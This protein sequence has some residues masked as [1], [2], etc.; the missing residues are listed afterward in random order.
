MKLARAVIVLLVASG[1]FYLIVGRGPAETRGG[2]VAAKTKTVATKTAAKTAKTGP[3]K[4]PP[5]NFL[6]RLIRGLIPN[7]NQPLI[8]KRRNKPIT[9]PTGKDDA[10]SRSRLLRARDHIDSRAPH[11][12]DDLKRLRR[13]QSLIAGGE[14]ETAMK[15]I[16]RLLDREDDSLIRN[17]KEE[18]V[19]VRE[20]ANRLLGRSPPQIRA[21]YQLKYG[22]VARDR[23]DKALKSADLRSVADV[24]THYFHTKAGA[25]AAGKLC[26]VYLD[27][28]EYGTA[29]RWHARL[30][31][32]GLSAKDDPRWL[33]QAAYAFRR[34]GDEAESNRLLKRVQDLQRGGTVIVAGRPVQPAEWLKRF[35]PAVNGPPTVSEWWNLY[36]NPSR[37]ATLRGGVP[38]LLAR[39]RQPVTNSHPVRQQIER[40]LETLSDNRR[41]MVPATIPLTVEGKVI[42]RTL[43][44]VNVVD[45]ETG[46]LLWETR[47]GISAERLLSGMPASTGYNSRF[48][49]RRMSSRTYTYGDHHPLTSLLFRNGNYGLLSS[50]GERLFVI[51][52]QALL[53]G[54]NSYGADPEQN[55][56]Y[57]RSWLTNRLTAYELKTGRPLWEAG[58][59]KRT[60]SFDLP[61]AG[62]YFL[63]VPVAQGGELFVV[64][65]RDSRIRLHVLDAKTGQVKWSRLIAYSDTKIS[66][67]SVRHW[68]TAQVAVADGVIICPTT[69]GW[70]VAVDRTN[71]SILWA[72][73]YSKPG[74]RS[75]SVKMA[76]NA[77][78]R[79]PTAALNQR[80]TPSAPVVTGGYV[81]YTPQEDESIVCARLRDGKR[82]WRIPKGDYLYLAGV[83]GE[84]VVLV[85]KQ[86]VTAVKLSEGTTAWTQQLDKS[87]GFPSGR[88]V[89]ADGRYHL[90][91]QSGQLWTF[92]VQTGKVSGKLYLPPDSRP[93]GNLTMYRRQVLSLT[94][95]GLTS[96][97]QRAALLAR[98]AVRKKRS[99]RDAWAALKEAE[100]A[101]LKR[102][103]EASLESLRDI[104][105]DKLEPRVK[106]R[107]R[108][109]MLRSLT[110]A[111]RSDFKAHDA[112]AKQ[113][114]TFVRTPD[115]RLQFRRLAAERHDARGEF[116]QAFAAYR[117][118]ARD[119]G[120]RAITREDNP[121]LEIQLRAWTAGKLRDVW[122]RMPPPARMAAGQELAD[123]AKQL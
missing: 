10:R 13:A 54:V 60:E 53:P 84:T 96:F 97:E 26:A 86:K 99:P 33:L 57:R 103:F 113:L 61:L 123:D 122:D 108:T 41:A 52:N 91:L 111:V 8:P 77:T 50:D 83:F 37:T 17:T 20:Q 42:Y 75:N 55:D 58:G 6:G 49:S 101:L 5:K 70:M 81:V 117:R 102:D 7:G 12:P 1:F 94:P 88:G 16:Q 47:E 2:Q 76:F 40:L 95:Y 44:G 89:A 38:L 78:N 72:Q 59:R 11:D 112:E 35:R 9:I 51:E 29:A 45:A 92:D 115:E 105:A 73:R 107:Y 104:D 121:R 31:E 67:D 34:A 98:I 24:A 14:W 4:K 28:G 43:R 46:E 32:S 19:S 74:S 64:G 69:V 27:R 100:I 109:A 120:D 39:W 62:N 118:L 119:Y 116:A 82:A 21:I 79:M 63:G 87:A 48:V 106:P 110:A 22:A 85:G 114:E 3:D 71:R 65:E 68:F 18:W 23:L 93:L 15:L 80:W 90:P 30:L 66:Q 36:G 56:Q 25:E